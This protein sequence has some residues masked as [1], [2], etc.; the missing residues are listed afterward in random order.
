MQIRDG[1]KAYGDVDFPG[2]PQ[3]GRIDQVAR[4]GSGMYL[5]N[6]GPRG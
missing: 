3:V 5:G 2:Y 6:A 1:A 4:R